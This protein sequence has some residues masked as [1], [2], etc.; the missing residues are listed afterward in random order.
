MCLLYGHHFCLT[1]TE[2]VFHISWCHSIWNSIPVT[3][4]FDFDFDYGFGLVTALVWF[5][6]KPSHIIQSLFSE[7]PFYHG[8][9]DLA[10][11]WL[12]QC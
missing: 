10:F 7:N 4:L 2:H 5:S 9:T 6:V 8:L 12:L 11:N 3:W 1:T